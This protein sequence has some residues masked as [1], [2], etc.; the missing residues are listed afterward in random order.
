MTENNSSL[1]AS[2]LNKWAMDH[3]GGRMDI[4]DSLDRSEQ[5]QSPSPALGFPWRLIGAVGVRKKIPGV[6]I[7]Y[8]EHRVPPS[9][10]RC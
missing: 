7:N 5:T 9:R 6:D 2:R 1:V 4:T 10:L 8:I 3:S